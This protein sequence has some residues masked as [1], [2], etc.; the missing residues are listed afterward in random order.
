MGLIQTMT[1]GTNF[2]APL[3]QK[4]QS[5]LLIGRP[6]VGKSTA[7]RE[8]TFLLSNDPKL[9]V[10]V[11][12]KSKELAGDGET[13][14]PAIGNARWLPVGK[15]DH[16]HEIMLEA[17]E[18]QSPDIVI[19]D[20]LSN[21]KEVYAAQ[22][23]A[24]RGIML[25][26]TA[27]GSTLPELVHDRERTALVGAIASVTLSAREANERRDG[28]KQVLKRSKEPGT[29]LGYRILSCSCTV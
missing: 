24:Q 11:V 18:N 17:V 27:H 10:V 15:R 23:I 29:F 7:L 21:P 3:I 4:R 2:F 12:D 13:P 20:E 6:G 8:I 5:L 26:A 1:S 9:I 14:H 22:T 19:V 25:I 28:Q 16:Q